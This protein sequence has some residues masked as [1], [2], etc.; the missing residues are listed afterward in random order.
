VNFILIVN[1][2]DTMRLWNH[3]HQVCSKSNN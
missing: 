2:V 3:L 1:L